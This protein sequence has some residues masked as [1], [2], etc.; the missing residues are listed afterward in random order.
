MQLTL[1]LLACLQTAYCCTPSN[2]TAPRQP[3]AL[4]A[5]N[6]CLPAQDFIV[7]GTNFYNQVSKEHVLSHLILK[8]QNVRVIWNLDPTIKAKKHYNATGVL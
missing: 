4:L 5:F 8:I 6:A 2:I 7:P 1:V 3:M